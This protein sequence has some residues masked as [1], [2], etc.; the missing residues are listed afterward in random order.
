MELPIPDVPHE[1]IR[2]PEWVSANVPGDP[3]IALRMMNKVVTKRSPQPAFIS[4]QP[5][6]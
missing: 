1:Y 3:K 6:P 2:P 5:E 4:D